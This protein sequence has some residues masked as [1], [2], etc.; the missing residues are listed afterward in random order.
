MRRPAGAREALGVSPPLEAG[1]AHPSGFERVRLVAAGARP[2]VVLRGDQP[3]NAGE[4]L[5]DDL[6]PPRK[7]VA[8]AH[9]EIM[10][11]RMALASQRVFRRPFATSRLKQQPP[12]T[13]RLWHQMTKHRATV[14]QPFCGAQFS[15]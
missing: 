11:D 6:L 15:F 13:S 1:R 8:P 4:V 9:W 5:L 14:R 3:H 2:E 7:S 10:A 12:H